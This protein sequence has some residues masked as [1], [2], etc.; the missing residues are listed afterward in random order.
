MSN[1]AIVRLAWA[2]ILR[3]FVGDD[4]ICFGCSTSGRERHVDGLGDAVGSFANIVPVAVS[5]LPTETVGSSLRV[6]DEQLK[7]SLLY[8]FVAIPEIEHALALQGGTHLFNTSISYAEEWTGLNS[9]S[10]ATGDLVLQP[11]SQQH[12]TS[13][14]VSLNIRH[15]N[16]KLVLDTSSRIFLEEQTLNVANSFGVAMQ[17]I[18]SSVDGT[19]IRDVSLFSD[20]DYAQIVAWDGDRTDRRDWGDANVVHDLVTRHA[21]QNPSS[22]GVCAWDGDLS[23]QELVGA[24]TTL[25]HYLVDR[26]VGPHAI[27]PVVLAKTRWAPVAMLAILK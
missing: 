18:L 3:S 16:G 14:D 11:V 8:Q 13:Y 20:R 4:D 27:V 22:Q 15:L 17:A 10:R 1:E 9:N 24:A 2:L 23:Y 6:V 25:A 26:G 21:F 12:C 19:P 7:S 5:L